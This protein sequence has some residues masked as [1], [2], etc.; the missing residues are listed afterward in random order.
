MGTITARK[1]RDGSIGYT[2]QIRIKRDGKLAYTEAETF[3]R[4][5]MA[6]EWMRRR[7]ADLDSERVR[8]VPLGSND[9]VIDLIDWYAEEQKKLTPWG[10]S[11]EADLKRLKKYPIAQK[12]AARLT[13]SDYIKHV[14]SRR[15]DGVGPSTAGN[16]LIWLRQ[17]LRSA[18][19]NKGIPIEMQYLDDA[20]HELR[21][22]RTIQKSAQ[23][24]RRLTRDE[25][26]KLVKYF[27]SRDRR[28]RIPMPD[29]FQFAL[30]TAR[31]EAEITQLT[32]E[33][34]E[35]KKKTGW[36]DD[37]KDPRRKADN[38]LEFRILNEA[39]DIIGRQ[40]RVA[41]QVFPYDPKSIGAA[42]TRACKVLEIEDL[43]FHDLRHEAASRLFE[44]GY[45]IQEVAQFT[46]HKSW[47]TL[48]RYTHLRPKDVPERA[49]RAIRG[50]RRS[51]SNHVE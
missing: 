44:R 18:R 22:R 29:I 3:S 51:D 48:K 2:A 42:F 32:W 23:R 43:H 30:L 10:R 27:A 4:R 24:N 39:W 28:A 16:D 7:E 50:N 45:S 9:K 6:V 8:G 19:A 1:R 25:E 15:R 17:V 41:P 34:L 49:S 46:L 38:R 40:P 12:V 21:A 5:Q 37:V 26:R 36:L 47:A 35:R 31:R 20:T 33:D 14:E 13:V 11:K